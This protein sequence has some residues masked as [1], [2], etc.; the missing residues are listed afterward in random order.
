MKLY[1]DK[2]LGKIAIRRNA[3]AKRIIARYNKDHIVFTIPQTFNINEFPS[4]L[5]EMRPKLREF[6]NN[7]KE[8]TIEVED[9][10]VIDMISRSIKIRATSA[11]ESFDYIFNDNEIEIL[12]SDKK[13]ITTQQNQKQLLYM[14]NNVVYMEAQK[15]LIPLTHKYAQ[16]FNLK[17]NDVKIS[18][19]RGRWGSCSSKRNI[20]L[21][22]YLMLLPE[23]LIHYVVLH[24]LTH[25]TE[26]NHSDKFWQQLDK[27]CGQDSRTL[28]R[29]TKMFMSQ[30]LELVR[31]Y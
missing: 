29:R 28:G 4:I 22:Y 15:V 23:E 3:Q 31:R 1:H 10:L 5:N 24:E 7:R 30:E 21:S 6:L 8:T 11:T 20:N 25:I 9:G 26:M 27:M 18:K 16:Q 19:S 14:I 13:D 12:I 17:I 2:E